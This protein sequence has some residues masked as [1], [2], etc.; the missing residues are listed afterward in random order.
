MVI[1]GKKPPEAGIAG[2]VAEKTVQRPEGAACRPR[3]RHRLPLRRPVRRAGDRAPVADERDGRRCP[4]RLT[5][6]Y[7]RALQAAAIKAWAGKPENVAAAQRAFLHRA[8]MNSLAA[9]G[10]LERELEKKAA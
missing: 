10:A 9:T 4:W 8:R 3:C 5:F 2:E 1:A 6:S 7:G